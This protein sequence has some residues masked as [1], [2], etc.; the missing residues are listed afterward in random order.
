[1]SID[2]QLAGA[3]RSSPARPPSWGRAILVFLGAGLLALGGCGENTG[4]PPLSGDGGA[5]L[6]G[7]DSVDGG[8]PPPDPATCDAL[9]ARTCG[10]GDAACVDEASCQAALLI[11]QYEPERCAPAFDDTF[12]YP[13]CEA[14]AC[15]KLVEKTC[16]SVSAPAPTCADRAGCP[17]AL[18]LYEAARD[19]SRPADDRQDAL[20][21]CAAGLED[22]VLF[23]ACP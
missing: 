18:E 14:D 1:M 21:A 3:L 11:R 5:E 22:E 23:P 15:T 19:S 9:V 8:E 20:L 6:V 7:P 13:P 10:V 2:A 16:G 4:D 12:T 17:P